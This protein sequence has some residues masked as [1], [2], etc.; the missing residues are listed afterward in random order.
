MFVIFFFNFFFYPVWTKVSG[1]DFQ[2]TIFQF[3]CGLR[4]EQEYRKDSEKTLMVYKCSVFFVFVFLF[5]W[6]RAMMTKIK[7]QNHFRNL[8]NIVL[9]RK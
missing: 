9:R 8:R 5:L 3:R 6:K 2:T 7:W 4:S 1:L